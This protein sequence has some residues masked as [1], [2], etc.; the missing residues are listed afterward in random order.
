MPTKRISAH[1]HPHPIGSFAGE[2]RER[3]NPS[4]LATRWDSQTSYWAPLTERTGARGYP[5][6]WSGL[7]VCTARWRQAPCTCRTDV[8]R[9]RAPSLLS[10]RRLRR[11]TRFNMDARRCPRQGSPRYAR[12]GPSAAVSYE[13]SGGVPSVTSKWPSRH[14]AADMAVGMTCL[15]LRRI[16]LRQGIGA[17]EIGPRHLDSATYTFGKMAPEALE[18]YG[19]STSPWPNDLPL[20]VFE[21]LLALQQRQP[22]LSATRR[23]EH[24]HRLHAPPLGESRLP[25]VK[26]PPRVGTSGSRSRKSVRTGS[27]TA[28]MAIAGHGLGRDLASAAL[29]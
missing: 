29:R 14:R 10:L 17:R 25:K 1:G 6:R 24:H 18:R 4:S 28:S 20:F 7:P 11:R 13:Q 27:V 5:S 21:S 16:Q 12:C 9:A 2:S 19:V 26:S 8:A 3:A 22:G 23:S 15:S